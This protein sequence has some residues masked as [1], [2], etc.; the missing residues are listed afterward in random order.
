MRKTLKCLKTK[1][2]FWE[3]AIMEHKAIIRFSSNVWEK[4]DYFTHNFDTEIGALGKVKVKKDKETGE[5]YFYVYELLF[6]QQYVSG[7][8]VHFTGDMWGELIKQYGLEGLKDVAFYWHRH[9]G[10]SAHSGTDDV[11]TFETFMSKEANRK[12]FSFLQTAID[13][14]GNWNDEAR[15]DIRLP[16]RHTILNKDIMIEVEE[17]PEEERV[18][19]E[20]NKIAEKCIAKKKT[21][22]LYNYN[23]YGY[24]TRYDKDFKFTTVNNITTYRIGD[25]KGIDKKIFDWNALDLKVSY[26]GYQDLNEAVEKGRFGLVE[27]TNYF[28][29]DFLEGCLTP[30][31]D[32]VSVSF[33]NGQATIKAGSSYKK[34]L[35]KALKD[36]EGLLNSYVRSWKEGVTDT[37]NM[38]QYNIQ[39]SKKNFFNMKAALIRSYIIFC[40]SLIKEM[41]KNIENEDEIVCKSLY[42]SNNEADIVITG[43]VDVTSVI[44]TIEDSCNINWFSN[45]SGI[46]FDLEMNAEIG[47]I[48]VTNN[49]DKLYLTGQE[50]IDIISGDKFGKNKT[51]SII[52]DK[53]DEEE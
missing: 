47:E 2:I 21:Q 30:I 38:K 16:I 7:A 5:K 19:K 42:E 28:N 31:E 22:P 1:K 8:T 14:D 20:C 51:N 10:N 44:D 46:V 9:P 41:E 15:I 24:G 27:G 32:K 49:R 26:A 53:A 50:V 43:K 48:F 17:S 52:L 25:K 39:P 45:N 3:E 29:N 23:P 33:K 37:P 12:Y 40:D 13:N 35:D 18:R 36:K 6:P 4:I 34:L 11:D